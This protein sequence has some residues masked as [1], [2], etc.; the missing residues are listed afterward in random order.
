MESDSEGWGEW[1]VIARDRGV[2]NDVIE[3]AVKQKQ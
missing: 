3:T 2:E 1:R